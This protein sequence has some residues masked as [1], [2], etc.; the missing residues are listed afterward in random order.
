MKI[1]QI[2]INFLLITSNLLLFSSCQETKSS[3]DLNSPSNGQTESINDPNNYSG[4]GIGTYSEKYGI[5]LRQ[6][7]EYDIRPEVSI[8][9]KIDFSFFNYGED[10]RVSTKMLP[11]VFLT[12]ISRIYF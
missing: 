6:T 12:N 3:E 5:L 1:K 11:N 8:N 2:L 7:L 4:S 10:L 9:N